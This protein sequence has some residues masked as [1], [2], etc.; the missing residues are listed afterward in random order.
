MKFNN[1]L[2]VDDDESTNR[3]HQ[4]VI[5][6]LEITNKITFARNGKKALDY[7]LSKEEFAGN[8]EFVQPEFI[9]IDLN[10]PVMSGF[11]FVELYIETENFKKHKPKII[12]LST[13]LIPEEKEKIEA[14]KDIFMFL[15]KPLTKDV[16]VSVLVG[17]YIEN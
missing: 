10:M 14:N 17:N 4:I 11:R 9:I 7:L 15:N 16:I 6:R 2:L 5:N 3:F 12:V 13:S 8:K 1:I